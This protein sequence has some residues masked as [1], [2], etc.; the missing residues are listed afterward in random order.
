MRT[1]PIFSTYFLLALFTLSL[2]ASSASAQKVE[3]DF[4]RNVDF[5]KFKTYAWRRHPVMEADPELRQSVGAEIARMG[6]SS[7]LLD[8]GFLPADVGTPD[9][10]VTGFGTRANKSEVTGSVGGWYSSSAYW[11][12]GWETVMVRNFVEGTL[13]IDI[14]DGETNELVWRAYCKGVVRDP[15]K[16]DKVINKALEKAFKK[17]PPKR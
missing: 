5:T 14:V 9:F 4:D 16:R 7:A 10:Y 11:A 2:C 8:R 17:F 1:A 6:V 15:R 13:V 12:Q 3:V